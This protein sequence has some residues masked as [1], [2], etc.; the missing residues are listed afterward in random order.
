M[1]RLPVKPSGNTPRLAVRRI[2]DGSYGVTNDRQHPTSQPASPFSDEGE[3]IHST[4]ERCDAV[5]RPT[6]RG[7]IT[8]WV[9][10]AKTYSVL[11][12][13]LAVHANSRPS[14]AAD[15]MSTTTND[16]EESHD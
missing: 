3:L 11:R 15:P 4:V 14:A 6:A 16:H 2:P 8:G 13:G 1:C 7:T 12:G 10:H 9:R 5:P